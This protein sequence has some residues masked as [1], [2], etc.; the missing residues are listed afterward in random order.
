[1][2]ISKFLNSST[3]G[4]PSRSFGFELFDETV[5]GN[6]LILALEG[7]RK[8]RSSIPNTWVTAFIF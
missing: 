6:A 2:A 8:A 5:F 1:M 3:A 4:K 7:T